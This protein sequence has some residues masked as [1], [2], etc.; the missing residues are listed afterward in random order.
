MKIRGL[1]NE[2]EVLIIGGSILEDNG[3]DKKVQVL[4]LCPINKSL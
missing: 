4:E 2:E 1:V 3:G